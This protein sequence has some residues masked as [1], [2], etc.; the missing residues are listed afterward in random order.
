MVTPCLVLF[1]P[2][3]FIVKF[4]NLHNFRKPPR[5]IPNPILVFNLN[6]CDTYFDMT[7]SSNASHSFEMMAFKFARESGD[8]WLH[9]SALYRALRSEVVQLRI[10]NKNYQISWK[11]QTVRVSRKSFPNSNTFVTLWR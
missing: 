4:Y 3:N 8:F 2:F 9:N 6:F 1:Q 5:K 10:A 11:S 7:F